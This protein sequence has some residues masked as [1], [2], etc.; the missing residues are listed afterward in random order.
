[1]IFASAKAKS[2]EIDI[3]TSEITDHET[4]LIFGFYDMHKIKSRLRKKF[5]RFKKKF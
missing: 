5:S 1:M 3:K 2:D 4:I